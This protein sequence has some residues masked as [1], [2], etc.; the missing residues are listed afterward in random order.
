MMNDKK[1]AGKSCTEGANEKTSPTED[2]TLCTMDYIQKIKLLYNLPENNNYAIPEN[3]II[4]M[5]NNLKIKLPKILREYYLKLGNNKMINNSFNRLLEPKEVEF[6]ENS[7]YLVFYEENQGVAY[8]A[9]NRND[10]ENEDPKVYASYD[11]NDLIQEWF[12]DSETVGNFLLTMAYWNGA[13]EGLNFSANYS[14]DDG[15]DNNAIKNIENNFTEIKGITNQLLRFFTN[16]DIGI[17]AL[18][19]DSENKYNGIY[20][21]TN[22]KEVYKK[23]LEKIN[24][25]WDYRSDEDNN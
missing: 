11:P 25:K 9:I 24:I 18:T 19:F 1:Y 17:I 5:E 14:N 22:N 8:W 7:K 13:L 16:N 15:I 21:G 12:I 10:I 2:G 20:I 4:A 3:E 23:I 6:T